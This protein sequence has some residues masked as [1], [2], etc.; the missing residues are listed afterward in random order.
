M[1]DCRSK[2]LHYTVKNIRDKRT[3]GVECLICGLCGDLDKLKRLP[4]LAEPADKEPEP[5]VLT[6]DEKAAQD[7]AAVASAESEFRRLQETEDRKVALE[8]MELQRQEAELEQMVLLHQLQTEEAVLQGLLNEQRALA[9]AEAAVAKKLEFSHESSPEQKP[10]EPNH[11]RRA[12]AHS[13]LEPETMCVGKIP[14]PLVS[15]VPENLPYGTDDMD[16]CPTW[17]GYG[18]DMITGDALPEAEAAKLVESSENLAVVSSEINKVGESSEKLGVS[19]KINKVGEFSAKLVVSSEINTVGESSGKC[20]VSSEINTGVGE[21]S[22]KL[23]VSSKICKGEESSEKLGVSTEIS[24]VGESE[25]SEKLGVSSEINTGVGESS[26]KLVSSKID[27]GVGRDSQ[28]YGVTIDIDNK[29]SA[30]GE[31]CGSQPASENKKKNSVCIA[32]DKKAAKASDKK[33]VV[34]DGK[35]RHADES[36]SKKPASSEQVV[37]DFPV[38]EAPAISPAEQTKVSGAQPNRRGKGKKK[39]VVPDEDD[40]GDDHHDDEDHH[41]DDADSSGGTKTR[42]AKGRGRGRGRGSRGGRA[43]SAAG[44]RGRGR[45]RGRGKNMDKEVVSPRG[46]SAKRCLEDDAETPGSTTKKGPVKKG[47]KGGKDEK[48]AETAS[49]DVKSRA[50][51]SAPKAKATPKAAPKAKATPK[52][53]PKAKGKSQAD[54]SQR[55]PEEQ[56]R[57]ARLSRKSVAYHKAKL[58]ATRAGKSMEDAVALAKKVS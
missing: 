7:A 37:P 44:A 8:L 26:E 11:P 43:C 13:Q 29:S 39:I 27:E 48:P 19:S 25:S 6:C 50:P 54:A 21:S 56:E 34:S 4:C 1:S 16:T 22:E 32:N 9:L 33:V 47:S 12:Q 17:L 23:G 18:E 41:D 5:A 57:R 52:A 55:T 45:G 30:S 40:D 35:R 28:M 31:G 14:E 36:P 3:A 53:A 24:K 2:G 42:A 51:K 58:E 15:I 10:T 38:D 49:T 46:A 20:V